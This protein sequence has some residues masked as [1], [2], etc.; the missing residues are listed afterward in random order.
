MRNASGH[1]RGACSPFSLST[2]VFALCS[3]CTQPMKLF[4][5]A[6]SPAEQL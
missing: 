1:F 5:I 4:R 6:P 3:T 2:P